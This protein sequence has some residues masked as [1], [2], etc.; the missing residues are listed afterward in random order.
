MRHLWTRAPR[1]VLVLAAAVTVAAVVTVTAVATTGASG[2]SG[3]NTITRFA[4]VPKRAFGGFSGD[5]GPALRAELSV[6]VGVAVDGKGNVY[7]ADRNN[8]RVRKVSTTGIISTIAGGT[9]VG[10]P[11]Y[12]DGGPATGASLSSPWGVAV[13]GQGNVYSPRGEEMSC[14]R[15]APVG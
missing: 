7:F 1:A 11:S 15:S 8:R 5:G 2:V 10:H 13:D 9:D 4:G 12:G 6:P 3:D 14:A